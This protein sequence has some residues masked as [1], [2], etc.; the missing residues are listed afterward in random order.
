MTFHL[1]WPT[2]SPAAIQQPFG[3]NWTGSP[4]FYTGAGLPGHEG[5]DITAPEGAEVYACADGVVTRMTM[6]DTGSEQTNPYGTQVR[7]IH[8]TDDGE[9]LTTYAHLQRVRDGLAVGAPVKAGEVI[10]YVG[11]T[12]K[13][14][15][16]QHLHLM[17]KKRGA[18]AAGETPFPKDILDPTPFLQ[19]PGSLATLTV[20]AQGAQ[21]PPPPL[22][23]AYNGRYWR[24][25]NE[26]QFRARWGWVKLV[27]GKRYLNV[28]AM[29]N[30][31][32]SSPQ[33]RKNA[34]GT[35]HVENAIRYLNPQDEPN[36]TPR[37]WPFPKK[38]YFCNIFVG[39]A[40]RLLYCEA[41]N[42][43]ANTTVTHLLN[44]LKTQGPATGWR[45]AANGKE[46]QEWVNNGFVAV[47]IWCQ[48]TASDHSAL[49]RPGRGF[50]DRKGFFWPRVAQA[51][52]IV[53]MNGDSYQTFR[54][55]ST[56]PRDRIFW[57]LH[58]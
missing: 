6:A 53:T 27:D 14:H 24:Q 28:I 52:A 23:T 49:V 48:G 44:W 40:T 18:S 43:P 2:I 19:P 58:E 50:V 41:P 45:P 12:G 39:D 11:S 55:N 17:L 5:I 57:F 54:G 22:A 20:E 51:G 8:Q 37:Y 7:I 4:T 33:Q 16:G 9:Y 31:P 26:A 21:L 30:A 35:Q 3:V 15:G 38:F 34:P 13:T 1:H 29:P 47:M 42:N 25:T 10:G 32:Y 36:G 46:A 56:K